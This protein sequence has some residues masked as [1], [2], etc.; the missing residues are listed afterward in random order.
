MPCS[1][2]ELL[3]NRRIWKAVIRMASVGDRESAISAELCTLHQDIDLI[4]K[5]HPDYCPDVNQQA[6]DQ[7]AIDFDSLIAFGDDV[8]LSC[9]L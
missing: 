2:F 9:Y 6:M 8:R 5:R 1:A 4:L 3:S 7:Q